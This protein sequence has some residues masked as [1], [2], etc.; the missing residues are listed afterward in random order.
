MN[1]ILDTQLI[2][3]RKAMDTIYN[4]GTQP[5]KFATDVLTRS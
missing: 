3:N 1:A 4:L 5:F 2:Q